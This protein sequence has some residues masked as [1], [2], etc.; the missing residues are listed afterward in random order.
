MDVPAPP[1][2]RRTQHANGTIRAQPSFNTT[3]TSA[4]LFPAATLV[5]RPRTPSLTSGM[6]EAGLPFGYTHR[7]QKVSAADGSTK[8]VSRGKVNRR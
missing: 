7:Q 8:K 3:L 2:F 4:L 6:E 1:Q 5:Y